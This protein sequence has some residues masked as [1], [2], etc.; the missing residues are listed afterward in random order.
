MILNIFPHSL[1]ILLP[2]RK[3]NS[4]LFQCVCPCVLSRFS[5][6]W[7]CVTLWT[8]ACQAPVYMGFSRQ[9]Y[10]SGLPFPTPGDLPDPRIEPMSPAFSGRF[11]TNSA[12][13]EAQFLMDK[14]FYFEDIMCAKFLQLDVIWVALRL[15]SIMSRYFLQKAF[16][17]RNQFS[18]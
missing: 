1:Q 4:F 18:S 15:L 2:F 5:H 13:Q 10:Y 14:P 17:K 8:A 12:T 7:L 3:Q 6:V 11:F 9:E 16:S